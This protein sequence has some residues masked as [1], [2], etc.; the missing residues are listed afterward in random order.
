MFLDLW[1]FLER[2]C[3]QSSSSYSELQPRW[4]TELSISDI[5]GTCEFLIRPE[6]PLHEQSAISTCE[7]KKKFLK[8]SIS[9]YRKILPSEVEER[10]SYKPSDA[11]RDLIGFKPA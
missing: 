6:E 1:T 4:D 9:D 8:F 2:K 5:N 7:I 11:W 10:T 3:M